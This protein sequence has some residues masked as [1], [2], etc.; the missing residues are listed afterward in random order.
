[1]QE[2]STVSPT[3]KLYLLKHHQ[4]N[5]Q[6]SSGSTEFFKKIRVNRNLKTSR[7]EHQILKIS[8][9]EQQNSRNLF[10]VNRILR[11]RQNVQQLTET[12]T[13]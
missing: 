5:S 13:F 8:V 9:Q 6:I 12:V 10:R 2:G 4:Q 1:M 7:Q 11:I 3:N